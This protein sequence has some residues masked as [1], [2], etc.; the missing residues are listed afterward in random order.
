MNHENN[1]E[2]IINHHKPQNELVAMLCLVEDV[3]TK[4]LF[5]NPA[6][7]AAGASMPLF[8]ETFGFAKPWLVRMVKSMLQ[9]FS[10]PSKR[11]AYMQNFAHAAVDGR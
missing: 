5:P 1:K 11:V 3:P 6:S 4:M 9:F 10:S 7:K 2:K 8:S